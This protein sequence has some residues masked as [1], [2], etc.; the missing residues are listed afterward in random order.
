MPNTGSRLWAGARS[1]RSA[2]GRCSRMTP[3]AADPGAEGHAGS[4]RR[5]GWAPPP[6][7]G[8]V[9]TSTSENHYRLL[10]VPYGASGAEITRAYRAAM[11]RIHPDRQAPE[12]QGAAEEEAKRLNRAYATLSKPLRRQAYDRTIRSEIVQDQ[13]MSRYVGGFHVPP[14]EGRGAD[15]SD[16]G[17]RRERT[18]AEKRELARADRAAVATVVAIFG[19]LVV[20]L[21]GLLLL[22]AAAAA[23]AAAIF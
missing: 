3:L 21:V 11:K 20:L 22:W 13:L 9:L 12:R 19:G 6:Q 14:A 8:S 23:V 7:S 2:G 15:R 18:A 1:D 16:L 5:G 10:G 4:G 17:L